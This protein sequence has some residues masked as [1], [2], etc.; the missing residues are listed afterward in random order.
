MSLI[1]QELKRRNVI[2]V[3][4]AYA[5]VA[6]L[7]IEVTATTF[8]ILKLPD[9]SVTLVTALLLIGLPL[10]LIF[11]WAYELTPEGIQLE[12]NIDRSKSIT[13]QTGRKLDFLIIGILTLALAYFVVDKFVLSDRPEEI[14]DRRVDSE[15]SIAVLPFVNMSP[16]PEQEFF[17][18]GL[19]E[20]I[21]NLLAKIPDLKVISRTSSFAFK[22]KNEDLRVVGQTLSV[23]AVLE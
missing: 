18:D 16:D 21:L 19:S 4:I 6:W 5:V 11:A 13:R 8:P 7:V 10:A 14:A 20:E 23:K 2:R 17:S 22:G 1:I 9:W 3:G 15:H 12:K